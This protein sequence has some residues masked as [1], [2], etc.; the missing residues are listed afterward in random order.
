MGMSGAC[1]R[2]VRK[3]SIPWESGSVRSKKNQVEALFRQFEKGGTQS[4]YFDQGYSGSEALSESF[5]N[6]KRIR[7]TVLD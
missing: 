3:V 4:G 2:T 6:Q 5:T 7:R 1:S